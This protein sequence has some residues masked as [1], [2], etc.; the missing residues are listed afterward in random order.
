MVVMIIS[1]KALE[2]SWLVHPQASMNWDKENIEAAG[3]N[4]MLIIG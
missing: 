2:Y 4:I 1:L 3:K